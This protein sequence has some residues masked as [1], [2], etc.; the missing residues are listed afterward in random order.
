[1]QFNSVILG[2]DAFYFTKRRVK[3]C[4]CLSKIPPFSSIENRFK[5]HKIY[6]KNILF[7]CAV[8]FSSI[9]SSFINMKKNYRLALIALTAFL[10][11]CINPHSPISYTAYKPVLMERESLE[12]SVSLHTAEPIKSPAKIFYKDNYILISERY[13]GV[14]LID[15]TNPKKP[16]SKGYISVPGCVD[17]AMKD[18][19]LYVDNAVDLVAIDLSNIPS[20]ALTVSS[21]IKNTFPELMPPD[22][23][24]IPARYQAS[25]RPKNTI[26][27]R[28]EK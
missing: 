5:Q 4:I 9:Y 22:G 11:S 6:L 17:M 8:A 24:P 10:S 7:T 12:R 25:N 27:V 3:L 19:T 23:L 21:R 13:K 15:N 14:H 16:V 28:W 1:M 2:F 18:N 20:L 26:I